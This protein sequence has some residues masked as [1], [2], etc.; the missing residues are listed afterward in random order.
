MAV[1]FSYH[2]S[3]QSLNILT[4]A[5][6]LNR[7]IGLFQN[8]WQ[9]QNYQGISAVVPCTFSGYPGLL[10]LSGFTA[11]V[12]LGAQAV[13]TLPTF[14]WAHNGGPVSNTVFGIYVVDSAGALCWAE[15]D[16]ADGVPMYGL[17]NYYAY[18]GQIGNQSIFPSW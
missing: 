8:D 9:P 6:W 18:T 10:P 14:T 1:I 4:A 16:P 11:A 7:W 5:W 12:Q 17:G 13:T 3:L 2:E 15:R